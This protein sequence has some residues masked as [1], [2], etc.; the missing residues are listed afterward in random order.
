MQCLIR[1]MKADIKDIPKPIYRYSYLK[2]SENER[3]AYNAVVALVQSNLVTTEKDY[4]KS[5]GTHQDSLLNIKNKGFL[6]LMLLN[7]R[8]AASGGGRA[9]FILPAYSQ[10]AAMCAQLV[11]KF[12]SHTI[13]SAS[14]GTRNSDICESGID[15]G[16]VVDEALI[17]K[18][19][20]TRGLI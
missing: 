9:K 15:N 16:P 8:I 20:H 3:S 13:L 10:R 5:F 17:R 2:M 14:S 11:K 7:I 6:S 18:V 4:F 19:I 1:H 12:H